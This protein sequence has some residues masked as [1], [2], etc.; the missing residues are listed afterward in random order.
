MFDLIAFDG[1]DT[2]WHN[3]RVYRMGRERFREVL[4]RTGV[5]DSDEEIEE[6]VNQTE[7]RNLKYYGYGVMSFVLSLIE[8]SI[9]ITGG[10]IS[11]T[12]ILELVRLSREMLTA[13]VELFDGAAEA[14]ATLAA[15]YPLMLITKGDL[16]HQLAKAEESGLGRHFRAIEVVSTKTPETYASILARHA[17]HPSRFLM[18]GNSL[19]SDV[20]PVL[21]IGGWAVHVPASLSW[22]HENGKPLDAAT[23]RYVELASLKQLPALVDRLAAGERA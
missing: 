18:V 15:A 2:L 16:L 7:L 4:A 8:A 3:E 21:E 9:E 13:E 23:S 10:R 14:V 6:R 19:R 1:D 5:R 17:V 22:A 12:D 11:G 20:L